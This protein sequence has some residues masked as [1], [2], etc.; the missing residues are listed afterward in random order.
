[1]DINSITL[2]NNRLPFIAVLLIIFGFV[3]GALFAADSGTVNRIR[4]ATVKI[5]NTAIRPSYYLPWRMK[6]EENSTGSGVIIEGNVI[7]TN[8]HVVSDS[9]YIEIQKENDP[10]KYR[11][12]VKFMGHQCDLA[13]LTVSDAR[14]FENT[15][16]LSVGKAIPELESGVTTYGYPTGGDRI[17]ITEGIISRLELSTYS[18]S[19]ES[20][21]LVLQTDAAINAGNSGGPVIQNGTLAGLSFQV[22]SSA[23]NIGY[24]IPA[25]VIRHFLDDIADGSFDGFPTLGVYWEKLESEDYRLYLGMDAKQTGILI[26]HVVEEG[27]SYTYLMPKDVICKI[28]GISIANDGTIP[29]NDGRL[30]FSYLTTSKQV[31]EKTEM[32]VFRNKKVVTINVPLSKKGERITTCNE[33]ETLPRYYIYGGIIFQPLTREFLKSW[34]TFWYNADPGLLYDY[35]FNETD[36]LSPEREEF[37]IINHILPDP[38]NTYISGT[39]FAVVDSING[40]KINKLEDLTGAFTQ[41]IANY[42]VI[43]LEGNSTPLVVRAP[44]MDEAHKRIL[45]K[46]GIQSDRRFDKNTGYVK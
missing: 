35:Y 43:K 15:K 29:F 44:A 34:D 42:H 27:P 46:Y 32:E 16:P 21:L 11:A 9:S 30:P 14:F 8:A 33:Y 36:N 31:G 19:L 7:L 2:N 5:A 23:E 38:A 3:C 28:G 1:M 40:K 12:Q 18:H 24:I 4:S 37:I 41:P 17:S 20:A 6:S 39:S 13:L 25:P 45:A 26:T 10:R 22:L